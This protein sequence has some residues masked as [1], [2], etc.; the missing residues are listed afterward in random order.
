[1]TRI[2]SLRCFRTKCFAN[3]ARRQILFDIAGWLEIGFLA[4][5]ETLGGSPP[6][7][8]GAVCLASTLLARAQKLRKVVL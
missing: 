8:A 6:R 5:Q 2:F 4:S 1:M 3:A 7:A